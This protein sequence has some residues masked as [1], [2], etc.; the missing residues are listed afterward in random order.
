MRDG[1]VGVVLRYDFFLWF[2]VGVVA[3]EGLDIFIGGVRYTG[4][5]VPQGREVVEEEERGGWVF[6]GGGEE[7]VI[8]TE[9]GDAV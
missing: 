6:E 1:D 4:G 2:G 5:V 8:S 7:R 3:D 9:K